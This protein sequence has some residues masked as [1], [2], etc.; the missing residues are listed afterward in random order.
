MI[1]LFK[2]F[3]KKALWLVIFSVIFITISSLFDM[4]QPIMLSW[5]ISTIEVITNSVDTITIK[6][7]NI[8]VNSAN[9]W[10]FFWTFV[11]SMF[12]AAALSLIFGLL[13]YFF[14]TKASL[15]AIQNMKNAVY[16]KILSFAFPELDKL[17]TASLITRLS[18]DT[19]QIQ[20][21]FQAIITLVIRAP[22][23]LIGGTILSFTTNPVFGALILSIVALI[24]IFAFLAF[25]K[26][27][28]LSMIKLKCLD[29][30]SDA[31][32]EN[33]LGVRPIKFFSLETI[34][35]KK[36]NLLNNKI[37]KFSNRSNYWAIPNWYMISYLLGL[38]ITLVL[39]LS[40]WIL[41]STH[42]QTLQPQIYSLVQ[43][44]I[45]VFQSFIT[46]LLAILIYIRS[47]PSANRINEVLN[48][49]SS[50]NNS[51]NPQGFNLNNYDIE[52]KDVN[53]KYNDDKSKWKLSNINFKIKSGETIGIIGLTGCGK[54]SLINLIPRLYDVSSGAVT[55][56]GINIKDI[57]L[58][59]LRQNISVDLQ[60]QIIFGGS[61]SYNL[62]YGKEDAT[63]NEMIE[64]CKNA[65]IWD[66]I[67]KLPNK[68]DSLVEHRGRNFSGGQKQ[69]ICLARALIKHPKI[70]ILDDTTSALDFATEKNVQIN[71]KNN[72][73]KMT[74][75]VLSQ[76]ISSVQNANKIIVLDNGL[77]AG[78]GSHKEL[79][80]K[81][82]IY[83]NIV[84]SQVGA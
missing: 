50:I 73:K 18:T 24:V 23:L 2:F 6:Y 43:I 65:C 3:R 17:T 36:F 79:I 19:T 13:G 81:C 84:K 4:V 16:K 47:A 15:F 42:D 40:G 32:R 82:A 59:Q 14:G 66:Y 11:G 70:L 55:I 30:V 41:Y 76:R 52:F 45:M 64:A 34:Q 31:I 53:F 9:A 80:K 74:K 69:R 38:G 27:I 26:S 77:I 10:M 75:I 7:L 49:N 28:I 60:E 54:T 12:G 83:S 25:M 33:A 22:V 78:I 37:T 56:G 5:V 39:L 51:S 44:M 1:R 57:D 63:Q 68:L 67:E 35:S 48:T 58:D 8:I 20:N 46:A 71:L 62:K 21:T 61:I 29:E 72:F